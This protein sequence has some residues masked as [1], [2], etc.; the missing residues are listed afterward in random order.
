MLNIP[1]LR[2]LRAI[3]EVV[4]TGSI[5]KASEVV[6]LSQP[7]I[8]QAIAKLEKNINS[9]LF[10]RTTDGMKPTEQGEAFSF[11]IE[12][13]LEYISK[14]ITDSLKVAKGQRKNSAQRYLF[15]ITTT[16]LKALIAVFN[17]QSFTEASR[18]LEVSQSSVYRASKDLEE[19]LGITLFEKNSTGI[20][21][22]KAGSALVMSSKLAFV[23]IK[24][25]IEEVGLLSNRHNSVIRVG[26]LP[27]ARTCLLP[28]TINEFS[29]KFPDCQIHVIDGPYQDLLNHLR[30]GDLDILIGALRFPSPSTDIRQETL[31][32]SYNKI[33]SRNDHP[34]SLKEQITL[35]DLQGSSWVVSNVNTPGR[36]M[37]EDIFTSQ[38]RDVPT[39]IVEA[40]SQMLVRELLLGSDRLTILSQHQITRELEEGHF[41]ILPF[42]CKKQSRPIGLTMRKNWFATSVQNHFLTLLREKGVQL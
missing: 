37:F 15:N 40:S 39:R 21:I 8:T 18:I 33:L 9:E 12:R 35:D 16:Q 20:T 19:I 24:Q 2:H 4:N 27:L 42:D 22:S 36:R 31:F 7:A 26:C 25:G 13:A 11:R 5:S 10:E 6:F 1:N 38:E 41:T 23:E 17:G 32:Q 29:R 14:G 34:L 28:N 30:H 3:S